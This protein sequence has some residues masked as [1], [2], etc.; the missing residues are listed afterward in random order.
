MLR[1][2]TSI[3]ERDHLRDVAFLPKYALHLM[4]NSIWLLEILWLGGCGGI[5]CYKSLQN[6]EMITEAS[7]VRR[8]G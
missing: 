7:T 5:L 3:S 4:N 6:I 2:F 1:I 8:L